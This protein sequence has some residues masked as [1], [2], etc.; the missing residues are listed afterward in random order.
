MR[1]RDF[2]AG[3]AR[4][5]S[6]GAEVVI[7]CD[8]IALFKCSFAGANRAVGWPG[9]WIRFLGAPSFALGRAGLLLC[10]SDSV[11]SDLITVGR[12]RNVCYNDA[13]NIL[14]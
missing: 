6:H 13:C 14:S 3:P 12:T 7:E 1:S 9:F 2:L 10:G 5:I 8:V 11:Q 4:T